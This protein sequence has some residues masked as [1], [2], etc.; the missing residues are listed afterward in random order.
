MT[1]Q[2]LDVWVKPLIHEQCA[3]APEELSQQYSSAMPLVPV[4]VPSGP[5]TTQKA[6]QHNDCSRRHSL[7][8]EGCGLLLPQ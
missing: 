3:V 1:I 8:S 7:K 6:I 5:T 2:V 4:E